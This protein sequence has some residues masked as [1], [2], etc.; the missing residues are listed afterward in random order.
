MPASPP[1]GSPLVVGLL[2]PTEWYGDPDAFAAG[3]GSGGVLP[4]VKHFPG[5]G[6][7]TGNSDLAPAATQPWRTLEHAGLLP[8]EAAVRAAV[9]AVMVAN[10]HVPG[11]TDLPASVS[12]AVITGVLRDQLGYHGLVLTDSLSAVSLS[13]VGY[14]VAEAS[15]AALEAGAD[16]VLFNATATTVAGLT[17]QT[18]L[19][20]ISAVGQGRLGRARLVDA[21]SH[22][23][24]AKHLDLCAAS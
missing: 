18:V 22:I 10:A 9:P 11:L 23:L 24:E 12:G 16:M 7:A 3:L 20:V 8:F 2:Y 19:A 5:L 6:G 17:D 4:V 21:V 13:S 14:S 15:T 1:D